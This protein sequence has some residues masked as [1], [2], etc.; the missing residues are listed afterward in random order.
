MGYIAFYFKEQFYMLQK[1]DKCIRTAMSM[2][3]KEDWA[4]VHAKMLKT[5]AFLLQKV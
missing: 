1:T 2:V 5:N 3:T 4:I